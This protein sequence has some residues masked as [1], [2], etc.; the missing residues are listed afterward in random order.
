[1]TED[2][3][4]NFDDESGDSSDENNRDFE[5]YTPRDESG[6]NKNT[7]GLG[8]GDKLEGRFV[9]SIPILKYPGIYRCIIG[10]DE[11]LMNQEDYPM[12]PEFKEW[13][14]G[15][16]CGRYLL[17]GFDCN[18]PNFFPGDNGKLKGRIKELPVQLYIPLLM[19]LANSYFEEYTS[20]N[21]FGY[22]PKN[23]LYNFLMDKMKLL[24]DY[25]IK[26]DFLGE[27]EIKT[28]LEFLLTPKFANELTNLLKL[29]EVNSPESSHSID[30]YIKKLDADYQNDTASFKN[31]SGLLRDLDEESFGKW[32]IP[33]VI[34]YKQLKNNS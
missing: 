24:S 28:D 13:A 6:G 33:I 22:P 8:K 1:M 5:K 15:G 18:A 30:Y 27:Y 26:N 4:Q 3:E 9:I 23:G 32:D 25:K 7:L 21:V 10:G 34:D 16:L 11:L 31:Y 12:L 29:L 19:N 20:A 14:H 2:F 17:I